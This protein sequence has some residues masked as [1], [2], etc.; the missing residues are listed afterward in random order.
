MKL[1]TIASLL[2]LAPATLAAYNLVHEHAGQSFFDGF[3]A[4]N[5]YDNLTNVNKT[6]CML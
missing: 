4:Y 3:S 5:S 2:P 6:L 1:T